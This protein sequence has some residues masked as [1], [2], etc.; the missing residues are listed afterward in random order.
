MINVIP[1]AAKIPIVF[2]LLNSSFRIVY[3]SAGNGSVRIIGVF[4]CS[5]SS[6]AVEVDVGVVPGKLGL[7]VTVYPLL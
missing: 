4:S 5:T 3:F 1:T 7:V 2:S 6:V